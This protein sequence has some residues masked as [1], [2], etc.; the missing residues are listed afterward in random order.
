M[1]WAFWEATPMTGAEA[2]D[3][4]ERL[5]D[6]IE[7]YP[8]KNCA[9]ERGELEMLRALIDRMDAQPKRKKGKAA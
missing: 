9:A 8:Y 4:I 6:A 7:R 5:Q 1:E 3:R 2:M